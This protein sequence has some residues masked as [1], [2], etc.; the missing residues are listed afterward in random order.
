MYFSKD[1]KS[2]SG[3]DERVIL[4]QCSARVTQIL[5]VIQGTPPA[6]LSVA[7]RTT[8]RSGGES[9]VYNMCTETLAHGHVSVSLSSQRC[10]TKSDK[11]EQQTA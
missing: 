5:Q 2:Q 1:L 6:L 9:N 11:H 8:V 4:E 3:E 7:C 10:P